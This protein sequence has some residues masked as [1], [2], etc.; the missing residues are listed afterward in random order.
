MKLTPHKTKVKFE[1]KCAYRRMQETGAHLPCWLTMRGNVVHHE[2]EGASFFGVFD[3][4]MPE[5]EFLAHVMDEW[6]TLKLKMKVKV[7]G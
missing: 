7:Y 1:A 5:A 6:E 4:R 2:C 3:T